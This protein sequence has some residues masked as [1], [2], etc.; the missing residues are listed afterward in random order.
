MQMKMGL[1][2]LAA[3][4]AAI[5]WVGTAL[6]G[7]VT[8]YRLEN[9]LQVVVIEDHRAP[10][11]VHMMWYRAGAADEPWGKSGIAHFFEHLMFKA[12]DDMKAGE[13]SEVVAANGGSDNAFTG[14]DYT[15]YFQRIAADRLGLMMKMEADRMRDLLLTPEDIV[16]ERDV[17]L[18]ERAQRTDTNPNALAREQ[19]GAAMFMNHPYGIPV[20]GWRHEVEKLE[21]EDALAF[22]RRFYAPDNAVL[23]V[24]GDVVPEEVLALAEQYYGPL[25]PTGNLPVRMRPSEPPQLA[26][27]RVIYNDARVSQPYL[28]RMYLA[29]E[30]NSGDQGEA[31]ALVYLAE[32]FGGTGATSLLGQAL[33]F[34]RQIAVY[35]NAGYSATSYDPTTFSLIVVPQPGVSLQEAEAAMD[36]VIAQFMQDGVDAEQFSRIKMQIRASEIYA[37][38]DIRGIAERYGS[39]L[40][41]GLTIADVQA[42]PDILQAVTPEDVMAA[43]ADLFDRD[44][45][46]TGWI[47]PEG[48]SGY[49]E[50]DQ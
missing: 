47:M 14:Q 11:V 45:S 33:Q 42:W 39:A 36:E 27:R 48:V 41:S 15:A 12:T 17:I 49:G 7:P 5:A 26:E 13:F 31:A 50:A 40:T 10:V 38:D 46:V 18:E 24:A 30:R 8:D 16:T 34:D 32:I 9:G 4:V 35:A 6:A 21:R 2:P 29:P 22:Y 23:V 44:R 1:R 25:A 20:I 43:A 28:R 37:L 19:M 3:I